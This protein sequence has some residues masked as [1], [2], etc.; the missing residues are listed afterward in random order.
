M[1]GNVR[2]GCPEETCVGNFDFEKVGGF[3]IGSSFV[4]RDFLCV[5]MLEVVF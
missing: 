1:Y 2:P 5:A 4:K 3:W